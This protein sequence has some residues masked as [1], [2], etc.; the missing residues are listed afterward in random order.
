MRV[1]LKNNVFAILGYLEGTY[2]LQ[3]ARVNG[4]VGY[5]SIS[6][7][8]WYNIEDKQWVI[9]D[10]VKDGLDV[11]LIAAKNEFGGL[12]DSR[13]RWKYWNGSNWLDIISNDVSVQCTGK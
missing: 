8:I 10:H 4:K 3:S 7:A 6:K 1:N 5:T 13:N 12:E 11:P 2:L 9:G